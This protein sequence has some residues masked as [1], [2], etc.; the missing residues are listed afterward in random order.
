MLRESHN[1]KIRDYIADLDTITVI[2]RFK[3][4]ASGKQIGHNP[5]MIQ[6]QNGRK[7]IIWPHK[8]RTA[9]PLL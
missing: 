5:I 4:D 6:W 3:V 2:G 7:E 1:H 9:A 8:M